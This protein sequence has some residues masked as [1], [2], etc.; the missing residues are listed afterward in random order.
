MSERLFFWLK[1]ILTSIRSFLEKNNAQAHTLNG[2]YRL[3]RTHIKIPKTK[4]ITNL[5]RRVHTLLKFIL[6]IITKIDAKRLTKNRNV[7]EAKCFAP[8]TKTL[9]CLQD[10]Q[11]RRVYIDSVLNLVKQSLK[12]HIIHSCRA[13]SRNEDTFKKCSLQSPYVN[14]IITKGVCETQCP[15]VVLCRYY[16]NL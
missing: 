7:A 9:I 12:M 8:F 10:S 6:D 15:L 1:R 3:S 11:Q 14:R 4:Y 5:S 16:L 2:C 13:H